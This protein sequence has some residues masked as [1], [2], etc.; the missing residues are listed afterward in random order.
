MLNIRYG[1]MEKDGCQKSKFGT[2]Y[3]LIKTAEVKMTIVDVMI[4]NTDDKVI[5]FS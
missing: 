3:H 1:A 4:R 2:K 5:Y